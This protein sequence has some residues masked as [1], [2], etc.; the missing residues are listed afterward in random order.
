[1]NDFKDELKRYDFIKKIN[2]LMSTLEADLKLIKADDLFYSA[3]LS[4]ENFCMDE[5]TDALDCCNRAAKLAHEK[6]I[7]LE[8]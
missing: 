7:E 4:H 2:R 3:L 8:A 5:C 6:D 1:M